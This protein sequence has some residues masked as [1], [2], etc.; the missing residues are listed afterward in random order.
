MTKER[1]KKVNEHLSALKVEQPPIYDGKRKTVFKI[2][3]KDT[4]FCD[5]VAEVFKDVEGAMCVDNLRLTSAL[6]ALFDC[7]IDVPSHVY[8]P[9]FDS[10]VLVADYCTPIAKPNPKT[11]K[12]VDVEWT[13]RN[14]G[15]NGEEFLKKNGLP[16]LE[17]LIKI[18]HE[19][20]PLADSKQ[21]TKVYGVEE[22]VFQECKS[23]SYRIMDYFT[24]LVEKSSI[25][26]RLRLN[27][28]DLTIEFGRRRHGATV[29]IGGIST[30][31][32][33][34]SSEKTRKTA[35]QFLGGDQAYEIMKLAIKERM[36]DLLMDSEYQ[37]IFGNQQKT[38]KNFKEKN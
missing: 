13:L 35:T 27:V 34:I 26:Q 12:A 7:E 30:N 3:E 32:F 2:S 17:Q 18:N 25:G 22:E 5:K 38:N 16:F 33:R 15:K 24:E 6:F 23:D 11:G 14:I 28:H 19:K 31:S 29:L 4:A 1:S 37:R 36:N 9:C 21:L 8:D 10:H 20:S